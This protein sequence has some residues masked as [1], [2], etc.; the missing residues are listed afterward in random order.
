MKGRDFIG[1]DEPLRRPRV[2]YVLWRHGVTVADNVSLSLQIYVL[3]CHS[4]HWIQVVSNITAFMSVP[5]KEL[6]QS[7]DSL[8]VI[9]IWIFVLL[10]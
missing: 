10:L 8:T 6:Q 4:L 7:L 5:E 1:S 2:Y 9:G 3:Y